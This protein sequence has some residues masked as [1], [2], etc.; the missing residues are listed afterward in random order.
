MKE[1]IAD[2][3]LAIVFGLTLSALALHYFDVLF[4]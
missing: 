2:I 4:Y 1:K 3:T